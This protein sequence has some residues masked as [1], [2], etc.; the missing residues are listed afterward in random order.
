MHDENSSQGHTPG[1]Q[2]NPDTQTNLFLRGDTI[3]GVCEGLGQDFGFHPNWLRAIFAGSFYWNPAIVI[4]AYL[5][6]GVVV[7]ISRLLFP[8]PR[9][10]AVAPAA[11]AAQAVAA[12]PA[13]EQDAL[14]LAA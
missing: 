8:A 11:P 1:D 6:L 5:A 3:L 4:G 13:D 12:A 14:A 9:A 10:T 7:A 2:D